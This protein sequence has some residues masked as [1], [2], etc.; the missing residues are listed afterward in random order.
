MTGQH[1]MVTTTLRYK[2]TTNK[3]GYRRIDQAMLDMGFLYN[4]VIRH[5]QAATGWHRRRWSLKLQNADVTDLHRNDPQFNRYARRLLESVIKRVNTSYARFFKDPAAGRPRTV[6]PYRFNTLEI[7]DPAVAHLKL[8]KDSK[9]GYVHVKGLPRLRFRTDSRLPEGEQPRIIRITRT[10]RRLNLC[11]V[12]QVKKE[13]ALPANQSVGI[14]PGVH[15]LITAVNE[16]GTVTQM[17]GL[18]DT[19]HCQL[20][21]KLRRKIQRQRD[22]ALKD[23]RARFVSHRNRNRELKQRFRWTEGPSRNYLKTLAQLRRV[24]QK[25]QDSLNGLQHRISSQ[26]VS[27]HQVVA[28]EDTRVANMT[29]SARGTLESPGTNVRQKAGLN[30][31]I[32]FQGWYGMRL[33]LEYKCQWYERDFVAIPAMNTSRLCGQCGSLHP[34]NRRSQS[35]FQ[36]RDCGFAANADLNAAENIRRQGVNLLARAENGPTRPPG[37]AA[38]SPSGQQAHKSDLEVS[39]S[40]S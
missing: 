3:G 4:A 19:K 29:R 1:Q 30:R 13:Q 23:G 40:N 22:S 8:A 7:S 12:F 31:A 32:L 14:D 24:E 27:E 2:A 11:L 35:S 34:G 18:K 21:R 36:C 15:S 33:K 28:I 5:R 16:K 20:M 39:A 6:S 17:E 26:L 9:T 38:G 10:Q 37:R 25:R